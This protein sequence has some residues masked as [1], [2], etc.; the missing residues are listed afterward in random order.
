MVRSGVGIDGYIVLR[1]EPQVVP[2][3]LIEYL[4]EEAKKGPSSAAN[5]S[6]CGGEFVCLDCV[7]GAEATK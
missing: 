5:F 6:C 2:P 7:G 4:Q 1:Q 3:K